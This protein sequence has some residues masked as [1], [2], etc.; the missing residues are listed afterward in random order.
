MVAV[1][2][3]AS[4]VAFGGGTGS[5]AGAGAVGACAAGAR[6]FHPD[7]AHI[8]TASGFSLNSLMSGFEQTVYS[9]LQSE[10]GARIVCSLVKTPKTSM[11]AVIVF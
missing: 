2:V 11:R 3:V 8:Y 5:G 9:Q 1:L 4:G 10:N 6:P 7:E